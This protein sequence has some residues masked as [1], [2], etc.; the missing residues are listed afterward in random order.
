MK[1]PIITVD[2]TEAVALVA[3]KINE[4]VAIYPITPSSGMGEFADAWSAVGKTNIWGT[5]PLVV[6]MQSEGGAAGAVHGALQAGAL[7][8]TFTASQGLLLMIPNMYKIAGELTS[9][10]FHVSA[11][12]LAAQALSIFGD[13]SDVTATRSTGFALL[14]SGSVQEAHDFALIAQAAT[15]ESRVPF[16]HFF[17]GF[18]VSHEVN[19]IEQLTDEDLKAM[20]D[21]ELVRA[22][23][24]RGL[25]PDRPVLRGTAQNPDVYFQ[26][27]ETV[28][29][30][31]EACPAIVQQA[32][33]KFAALTDRQY[34]NI[35]YFG[36]PDAERV[37]VMMGCGAVTAS[38][39]AKYLNEAGEKLGVIAIR[40]YRPFP[41]KDFLKALPETVKTI[42]VL[43]RTKEP[44]STGEPL[45]LDVSAAIVAGLEQGTASFTEKPRIIGG[46][47]GLSSKEFTPAMV[48]G[49]FEEMTSAKPKNSFATGIYDD[50]TNNSIDYDPNFS[51][52]DPQT[53]R[54]VFFGLGSDGTVGAN[55]NSIKIIGE[56]T[57]NHAQGFFNYD[58]KKSGAVTVSHLRFG[59]KP[60]RAPY[61]I[62]NANFVACHQFSFL[63][64]IDMLKY[65]EPKAVFLLN[66]FEGPDEVW[67][68]LPR[69]VQETIIEKKLRFYVID[70][71]QVAEESGMGRRINTIMQ[72]CF[73]AISGVLPREQAIKA[74][75]DAIQKTYGKRGE[76]VVKRNFEAVDKTLANLFEVDVPAKVT[77]QIAIR[78][79]VPDAAPDFVRDVLG[80]IIAGRGDALP[81][82]A[83][84]VDGT[85]P[86]ATTQWE[87]RNIALEIPAWEPDICIQ[88]GKC[89]FVCPHAVIRE[90]VFDPTLLEKSPPSFLSADARWKEF[91]NM[92][93]TL[94]VSPEDC[95]GC[96]LCIEACPAKD[97]T[98]VGRKAINMVDQLPIRER[99]VTNWDFFLTLP[100]VDRTAITIGTVKNSQLLQPLFEFSGAC[101][102]CGETPYLKLLTQLFGDRTIVANA[103]GCSSIYGGNLPT[104]P[105]SVNSDGR[106]PAWSNSLFEDNAE[107]GFG[108]RLTLDKQEEYARELLRELS[109]QFGENLVSEI[110]NSDQRTESG[111]AAQRERIALLKERLSESDDPRSKD[112][113]SLAD[114]LVKKSVWIVGGDGWAYD[115]GYGGLDHVLAMGRNVNILVL[116]TEVYSNTGGQASKAT[117]RAAVAKFA[118][119]GKGLPKKDLGMIA[120]SY[121]YVYVAKIAMGA[122]DQQTL[123]AF[124]E[125]DAYDGPSLIIAYSHCIAHGYDLVNGLTQQK[126]AVQSGFWP[127]FRYNPDLA[128]EGKNPL[129]IDSKKPTISFSE[130]AYN[131]TRYRM[132][133][134]SDEKRAEALMKLAEDDVEGRWDLYQQMAAMHFNGKDGNE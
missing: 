64:R 42:A 15:L 124:L 58:S 99:E 72:T 96:A 117:P 114:V 35:D 66:S 104:T 126:L 100:E 81:V 46:R 108:M 121:G 25:S 69:P 91:P 90:K 38:E 7:T 48:K 93:Y 79:P 88:C 129:I 80:E 82:S 68:F 11:R 34:H 43:D 83:F 76:A 109:G 30:Y 50:V 55:K 86:T 59:P 8:T 24:A 98:Q 74:I 23:R 10:V 133:L 106:G 29:P 31:Y 120:M 65:A 54:A 19:K 12:S 102:G 101:A 39:T 84:P 87:K 111:I 2:G 127:L 107:F 95:T 75:K 134:Q 61:L 97:K 28:N 112:L 17:E 132:L 14:S 130:Y 78:K 32:M 27:R 3:H 22:H 56:E 9:T 123:R 5:V 116:D 60:I 85:F 51:I 6:E 73:F 113:L 4:V 125:A 16:L 53:V 77:S 62:E 89:V 118:A 105:W 94:S 18:R 21:D 115:I 122:S 37:I 128:D 63:E 13:H 20:I 33:D 26:A 47:Y 71:Y 41:I 49:V 70:G 1:R 44:G 40:L 92:K 67:D 36:A 52:E 45:F 110:L 57:D 131:E 103:T 119:K